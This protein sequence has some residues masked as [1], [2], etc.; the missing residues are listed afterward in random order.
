MPLLTTSAFLSSCV[1]S[2]NFIMKGPDGTE[3]KD[4]DVTAVDASI[5]GS[6]AKMKISKALMENKTLKFS[7]AKV[8]GVE[9]IVKVEEASQAV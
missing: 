7:V 4:L 2:A 5:A 1:D 6:D 3:R 9:K 8:G